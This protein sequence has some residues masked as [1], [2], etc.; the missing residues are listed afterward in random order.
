MKK[1]NTIDI[2][3]TGISVLFVLGAIFVFNTCPAKEDGTFM[4]CHFANNTATA[5]GIVIF[6]LS[7]EN[8]FVSSKIKIGLN[9]AI[10]A[11]SI[12]VGLVPGILINLCK[13]KT[14]RCWTISRPSILI[15]AILFALVSALNL[16]LLIKKEKK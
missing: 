1:I 5:I 8:L 12:L 3:L 15:F 10:F 13:M 14:M 2:I 16:I 7:L 9:S 11:L 6:A 4:T